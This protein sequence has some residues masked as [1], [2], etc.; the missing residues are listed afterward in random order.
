MKVLITGGTGYIGSHTVVELYKAGYEPVIV[1]DLSNSD[2]SVLN[3][4]EKI[5]GKKI[6]FYA[7]D[8]TNRH[9]MEWLF[10]REKDI[11]AV[12]HFAAFKAVGESVLHPL[13]YYNNNIQGMYCLLSV[14]QEFNVKHLVFSSS[15][16]VYGDSKDLPV[17]EDTPMLA[18][19][20]PYGNTKK[21]GEQMI[22]DWIKSLNH[23]ERHGFSGVVLRYFNPIGAHPS[24][25]IGEYPKGVPGNLVPFITQVA[26]GIR[27]EL[28]VFGNDYPTPDG[29]CI[30]D[31]IHVCDVASAHVKACDFMVKEENKGKTTVFNIG[32][33][34]GNSVMELIH[35]FEKVSGL[36]LNYR[37][38]QRRAGDIAEIYAST[39]KANKELGWSAQLGLEDGLRDAWKWQQNLGI[40]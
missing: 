16:T 5:T 34:K 27:K 25:F 3:A 14:M 38:G 29:T 28:V 10:T 35:T 13:K 19:T 17:T 30:R 22:Q 1:D 26:A 37:I 11:D 2:F 23:Q 33:G 36:K 39:Q 18:A 8:C 24:G 15:S 21:V 31:F 9:K 32:T 40:L 7:V 20:S 6:N 4:I 12:I